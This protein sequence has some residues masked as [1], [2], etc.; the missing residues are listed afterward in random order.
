[1]VFRIRINKIQVTL[2]NR[3]R[4]EKL[5]VCHLDKKFCRFI[6]TENLLQ[7]L[8][9]SAVG[10]CSDLEEHMLQLSSLYFFR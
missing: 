8:K 3:V 6:E 1:M 2:R 7:F 5:I 10:S 9:Y 4:P